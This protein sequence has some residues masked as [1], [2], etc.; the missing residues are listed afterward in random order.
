MLTLN[1]LKAYILSRRA[2]S[3]ARIIGLTSVI[4]VMLSVTALIVVISIMTGFG[5]GI[6]DR[7]L[8]VE[9]HLV[10][11]NS[12]AEVR[13]Q[14]LS[15]LQ[16]RPGVKASL[17]ESQDL[18]IRTIDG[19]YGGASGRGVSDEAMGRIFRNLESN[20]IKAGRGGLDR[21]D[22]APD[23]YSLERGE[24]IIGV[25]LATSLKIFPGDEI[26][27]TSP[28]AMLLPSGEVPRVERV[29]VKTVL[30]TDVPSLDATT[31]FYG[32]DRSFRRLSQGRGPERQL[33][34]WLE[35][36]LEFERLKAELSQRSL[37]VRSWLDRNS[38]LFLSLKIEKFL[39]TLFLTLTFL[40]GSFSI[41]TVLVLLSSQKQSDM[42]ML[43]VM[44]LKR[45][46]VSRIFSGI[47]VGL[48]ALGI[49]AGLIL[50]FG[51]AVWVDVFQPIKLPPYYYDPRLP[52]AYDFLT[53]GIVVALVFLVSVLVSWLVSQQNSNHQIVPSLRK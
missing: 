20:R 5:S 9:P 14:L 30:R 36:P 41:V 39:M 7:I 16:Q 3:L 26:V 49:L 44:G 52:V 40:I 8:S 38:S 29:R 37:S 4:A 1:F 25:D 15:E 34:V 6:R 31:I 21:R 33:E 18:I 24:V 50:G 28:E 11:E 32:I 17:T 2:G 43:R 42:S 12:D 51:V 10:I 46:Q 19:G 13:N 23:T 48:S 45:F 22:F 27:V 47:G 53:V 35:N